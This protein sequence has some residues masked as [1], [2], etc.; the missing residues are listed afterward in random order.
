MGLHRSARPHLEPLEPRALLA[1]LTGV[2]FE[3]LNGDGRRDPA[4]PALAGRVVFL[5]TDRDGRRDAGE[6]AATTAANGTYSFTGL[7]PGTYTVTQL[8][9]AGWRPTAPA[10]AP[11]SAS[12][13]DQL[14]RLDRL[15]AD[16]RFTG[17]DGEGFS[18]AVLDTGLA[19]SH[20]A[21]DDAVAYQRDFQNGDA[22]A[23]D[24]T[25]HGTHVASLIA[26]RDPDHRGVAPGA[27][28]VGLKVLDD[29]DGGSF[30]KIEQGLRWVIDHADEY[31]IVAVNLS[32]GDG[33]SY[34]TP[35][36]LHGLGD[37]LAALDALGVV[38]VAAGGNAFGPD[39]PPGITY[40]AADPRVLAVG[41][42]WAD[43][44]GDDWE[45]E[46]GAVDHQTGPDRIASFTQR[47][48]ASQVF[49]PG[50]LLV[51]AAPDG[52]TSTLSGSSMAAAVVTG[53]VPLVQ[54][55]AVENLGRR[56]TASEV[57]ALI[58]Q[59][60]AIIQDGDDELDNV[61][62]SGGQFRRVDAL[63][64]MQSVV[65]ATG[66][67]PGPTAASRTVHVLGDVT[68]SLG[69]RRLGAVTGV[70]FA[71]RNANAAQDAGEA[72]L[73]GRTVFLDRN[74]NGRLDVGEASARTDAAG[75]YRLIDLGP[76]TSA[77]KRV[78]A[79]DE[80]ARP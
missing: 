25:G 9:P 65:G 66:V 3:D 30:D 36:S 76:G 29:Q 10:A 27:G 74:N 38:V 55:A 6:A 46:S 1:T 37:E 35:T 5:D 50:T 41:A 19:A 69:T 77:V 13:A 42:V 75:R 79:S 26:S 68:A 24:P 18:V 28:L 16:P 21:F 7:Q 53:L 51:G 2:A 48:P 40:P 80:V 14:I 17:L 20:P 12:A 70:V 52:G 23:D 60:G 58:R 62:N 49:A 59:S 54:Q 78:P 57:R 64:L 45:W 8:A 61:A 15:R 32:L 56:L 33:G 67:G 71:D 34:V 73:A 72:A 4:D 63:S 39:A 44:H 31:R 22:T 11:S 43:D 47:G